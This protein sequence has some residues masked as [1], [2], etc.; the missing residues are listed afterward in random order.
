[1]RIEL[2]AAFTIAMSA[3]AAAAFEYRPEWDAISGA[4]C[5]ERIENNGCLNVHPSRV[6][7]TSRAQDASPEQEVTIIG[8][9]AVCISLAPAT[10]DVRVSS[11]EP[12]Y[13]QPNEPEKCTSAPYLVR[14]KANAAVAL[15]VW[16]TGP[17]T[18]SGHDCGWEI[19]PQGV[20]QPGNCLQPH[21]PPECQ[22]GQKK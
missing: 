20:S 4:I 14:V 6:R 15:N 16:P 11:Q 21:P 9:Q 3:F 18:G 13:P 2:A 8:G 12:C 7:I 5:V 22:R 19:L 10:Y 17:A 1:M